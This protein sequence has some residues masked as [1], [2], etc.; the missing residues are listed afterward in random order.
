MYYATY[1]LLQSGDAQPGTSLVF[2]IIP[3]HDESYDIDY[4]PV[5]LVV[6]VM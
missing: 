5:S 6:T 1:A 3:V 4:E 2:T